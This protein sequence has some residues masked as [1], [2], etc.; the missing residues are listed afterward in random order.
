MGTYIAGVVINGVI[1]TSFASILLLS[2]SLP[3][4]N[5]NEAIRQ[6]RYYLGYDLFLFA[7][8]GTA[9]FVVSNTFSIQNFTLKLRG[10]WICRDCIQPT[11]Y[12]L[13]WEFV[14]YTIFLAAL[15]VMA[16]LCNP[17]GILGRLRGDRHHRHALIGILL[18]VAFIVVVMDIMVCCCCGL[19]VSSCL[20]Y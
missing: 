12:L 5:R 8:L 14:G 1:L 10:M 2:S 11:A 19:L 20:P 3:L 6:G 7:I 18:V 16:L 15:L 13:L 17:I 9:S 4:S